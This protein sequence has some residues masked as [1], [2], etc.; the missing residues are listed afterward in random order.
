M[1]AYIGY[2]TM[3]AA[4][5]VERAGRVIAVEAIGENLEILQ[6]NIHSNGFDNITIVPK[7]AWNS[8]GRLTL[9]KPTEYRASAFQSV[10]QTQG[11]RYDQNAC[12]KSQ[13]ANCRHL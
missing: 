1:G 11:Q 9:F 5:L 13:I 12:W 6:K 8:C 3:R 4:E 10:V 2:Y 7:A